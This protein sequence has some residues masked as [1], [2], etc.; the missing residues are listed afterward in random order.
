M[1][2]VILDVDMGVD[3]ALALMLALHSP[4]IDLMGI[5]TV[6]GNVSVEIGAHSVLQVLELLERSEIPVFVGGGSPLEEESIFAQE[7]HDSNGLGEMVLPDS[8]MLPA[9]DAVEF[10]IEGI[11]SRPGEVVL[12]ALGPL[13]NLALVEGR[14]P[15]I[16]KRARR[17][18]IMGGT[19]QGEGNVQQTVKYSYFTDPHAVR[20]VFQS[21]ANVTLVPFGIARLAGLDAEVIKKRL[22]QRS[23]PIANFVREV[24]RTV[25][26]Y[27]EEDYGYSGMYLY[28]S[29]VMVMAFEPA[30]CALETLWVDIEP[31]EK[32]QVVADRRPLVSDEEKMGYQVECAVK[33]DAERFLEIFIHR[34]LG[35]K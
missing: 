17:V 21:G 31:A 8:E 13:T 6:S 24:S 15:G 12:I 4:E 18:F 3:D 29:L 19:L 32:L 9:G 23:D 11:N 26:A 20:Q 30:L 7:I 10:L 25:I 28:A 22:E 5:S 33:V 16:L 14:H 35:D 1:Q 2:P 27:D 34:V